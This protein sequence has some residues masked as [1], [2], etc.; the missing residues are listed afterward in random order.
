MP[1][2][3]GR[4]ATSWGIVYCSAGRS[5]LTSDDNVVPGS[6]HI[7]CVGSDGWLRLHL[8]VAK[9]GRGQDLRVSPQ[10]GRLC[11]AAWHLPVHLPVQNHLPNR[12]A[13][14]RTALAA[15]A[16]CQGTCG[17][18]SKSGGGRGTATRTGAFQGGYVRVC[19]CVCVHVC[20]EGASSN[21]RD[22]L[23]E[24]PVAPP[25][26]GCRCQWRL[27]YFSRRQRPVS[28]V[29]RCPFI[30]HVGVSLVPLTHALVRPPLAPRSVL[31]RPCGTAALCTRCVHA[32][33]AQEAE[34]SVHEA[35]RAGAARDEVPHGQDPG[36]AAGGRVTKGLHD[37]TVSGQGIIK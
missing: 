23:I 19:V 9:H 26:T 30:T 7:H 31:P 4:H 2:A 25:G 5:T 37:C 15:A 24:W 12:T 18:A 22:F 27:E 11:G 21:C 1:R 13:P 29:S 8:L 36:G 6:G 14:H 33:R 16:G 3:P 10:S 34:G 35:Y 32:A 20:V 28:F 17:A